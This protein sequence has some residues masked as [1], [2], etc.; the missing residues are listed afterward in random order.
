MA[1]YPTRLGLCGRTDAGISPLLGYRPPVTAPETQAVAG[2]DV[3]ISPLAVVHGDDEDLVVENPKAYYAL[4]RKLRR[5]QRAQAR[6]TKGSR[7]WWEAQRRIDKLHRRIRG[8]RDNAQHQL[9]AHLVKTYGHIG[10]ESLRVKGLFQNGPPGESPWRLSD[11]QAAGANSVQGPVVRTGINS[12]RYLLS[13][14]QG[15]FRLRGGE[16]GPEAGKQLGMSELWRNPR[17][18]CKCSPQPA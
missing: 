7:G 10:T 11:E 1:T 4:E 8:I 2:V 16:S 18:G 13:V 15:L 5:W 9:S 14:Q 12:R 17:P 6:R 3:G